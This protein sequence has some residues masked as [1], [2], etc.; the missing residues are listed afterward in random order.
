[1]SAIKESIFDLIILRQNKKQKKPVLPVNWP[2]FYHSVSDLIC[3]G[4]PPD[5]ALVIAQAAS[6]LVLNSAFCR[7]SISTGKMLASITVCGEGKQFRL[8]SCWEQLK[9][10]LTWPKM[11]NYGPKLLIYLQREKNV[12][13]ENIH[14]FIVVWAS[15]PIRLWWHDRYFMRNVHYHV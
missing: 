5:V 10:S 2:V 6:F 1:M 12:I 3:S 11:T 15:V 4:V 8:V 13:S 9:Q 14:I 7:M